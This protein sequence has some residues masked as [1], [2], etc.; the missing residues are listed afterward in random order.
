MPIVGLGKVVDHLHQPV[1]RRHKVG[2]EDGDELAL[3][4]LQAGVERAGLVAVPVGAMD[5][6]DGVA[7]RGIARH[8]A[9]GHLAGFVGR[10]VEDLDLELVAAG[11]PW[12]R[13]PRSSR[14][15]TNCSLKMGSCTVTRGSSSKCLG[16]LGL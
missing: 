14:S 11:T 12:R 15:I 10:V 3:G 5:V 4:H 1:G 8:D 16:G 9:G 6:D 13:R 2:V 7:Q